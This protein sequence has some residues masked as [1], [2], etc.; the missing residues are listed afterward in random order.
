MM[1]RLFLLLAL[2]GSGII[3]SAQYRVSSVDSTFSS[4]YE[5]KYLLE[6]GNSTIVYGT[7]TSKDECTMNFSRE[8]AVLQ[9]DVRYKL[10]RSINIPMYD[11]AEPKY[12]KFREA[13]E[14]ANFVLEFD[15]VPLHDGLDIIETDNPKEGGIYLNVRG[16]HLEP[17]DIERFPDYNSFV[18]SYPVT[19]FGRYVENGSTHQY[20]LRNNFY[21]SCQCTDVDD[22]IFE[23]KYKRFY[24]EMKNNSDHGVLFNF[25]DTYVLGH[26]KVGGKQQDKYFTKYTPESFDDY[27]AQGDYYEAKNAVGGMKDVSSKLRSESYNRDNGEWANL[28]LKVLSDIT[29]GLAEKNIQQYIADHPKTRPRALKSQSLNPGDSVC[30]YLAFEKK[31][32]D[33]FTLH[34]KMDG[35]D[36]AFYWK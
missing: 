11:E 29:D 23:P 27:M 30:G 36:F 16:V 18:N 14:K 35:Y 5:M 9:D 1:K 28:G 20:Y 24:I 6:T 26:K 2:L 8:L 32:V 10:R 3:S 12:A 21:I 22:G 25:D 31:K 17:I 19:I 34:I 4:E 7:F 15:K 13:G 33:T